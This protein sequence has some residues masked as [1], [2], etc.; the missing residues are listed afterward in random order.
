MRWETHIRNDL[1]LLVVRA[2][3][4]GATIPEV[5]E[6]VGVTSAQSYGFADFTAETGDISP[7]K[8]GGYT[9]YALAARDLGTDG[10]IYSM[11]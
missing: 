8:F 4:D 11:Q 6:Q 10:P 7:A 3:Q 5:A 1:R 9:G 2:R